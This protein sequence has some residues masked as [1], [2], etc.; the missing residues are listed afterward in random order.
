MLPELVETA[1]LRLRPPRLEDAEAVLATWARDADAARYMTWTPH[2]TIDDTLVFL[3]SAQW[4]E[5]QGHRPWLIE[6]ADDARVIGMIGL[7]IEGDG[8]LIDGARVP[9]RANVGYALGREYWGQGIMTEALREV[10]AVTLAVPSMY[11]VY[12]Y[13]DVENLASARVME[14]AGMSFEGVL[15]RWG[16]HPN[17]SSEPRDCLCYAAVR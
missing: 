4:A 13:C 12:A 11:R 17:R 15:R 8:P 14:K 5:Q 16:V 10:I 9:N 2:R 1:R 3:R 7:T 6:R